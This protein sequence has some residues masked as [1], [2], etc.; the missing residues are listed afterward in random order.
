M[1]AFL[2]MGLLG[3]NFVR[4]ARRR[5]EDVRIWNRTPARA[6][7]LADTGAVPCADPATTVAGVDR[8]HLTLSDDVAVDAVLEALLPALAPG[9]LV[10]DHTTT[11]ASTTRARCEALAVQGV[12]FL[13]APVFMGPQNAH[14]ATGLMLVGGP[15]PLVE[16]ASP[17]LSAMTGKLVDLGE[18][19]ARPAGMKRLGNLFL[20]AMTAGLA[21]LLTL[22]RG[23]GIPPDEAAALFGV[24]NPGPSIPTRIGRM[25]SQS[26]DPPSW[27]LQMA[28]KDARLMLEEAA[29]GGVQLAVLPAIA[30]EMDRHLAQGRAAL[31][32]TVIAHDAVAPKS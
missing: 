23:L 13:H 15:R 11:A 20:M 6:Q 19:P 8:V 5:G 16:R 30:A 10:I 3:S 24:F 17:A 28:R 21:D 7:A 2:G 14:D 12:A 31:D 22:A 18:D 9:A 27:E 25:T 29:L 4:A 26:F 1:I 32:W